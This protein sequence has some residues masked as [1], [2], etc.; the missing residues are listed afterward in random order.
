MS[1][2]SSISKLLGISAEI[3]QDRLPLSVNVLNNMGHLKEEF[4]NIL[5]SGL[6]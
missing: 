4:E 1:N 3:G 5:G 2:N 6:I